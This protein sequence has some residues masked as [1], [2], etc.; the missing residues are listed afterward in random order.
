MY[1]FSFWKKVIWDA[2]QWKSVKSFLNKV[3]GGAVK[4]SRKYIS[5]ISN[6][7]ALI[8]SQHDTRHG[9]VRHFFTP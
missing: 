6:D 3:W 8:I 2:R 1:L 9:F 5:F 7:G 4:E